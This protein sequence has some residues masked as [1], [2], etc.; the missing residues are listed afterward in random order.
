MFFLLCGQKSEQA[1][2]KHINPAAK[3]TRYILFHIF[4]SENMESTSVLVYGKTPITIYLPTSLHAEAVI[5]L[6]LSI[7]D[8]LI[9]LL[10]IM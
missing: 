8:D 7:L 1:N 3:H 10:Y 4:N 6:P 2:R 5:I 9:L